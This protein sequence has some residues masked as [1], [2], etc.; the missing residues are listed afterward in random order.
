MGVP[1]A[2]ELASFFSFEGSTC[3]EDAEVGVVLQLVMFY[4]KDEVSFDKD[5]RTS[6][7]LVVFFRRQN[8]HLVLPLSLL[9]RTQEVELTSR[10]MQRAR[11]LSERE[12]AGSALS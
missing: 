11:R 9:R 8:S 10:F 3:L 1:T 4:E 5:N 2:G 7:I 12:A 6:P